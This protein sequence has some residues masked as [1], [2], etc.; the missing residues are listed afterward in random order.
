MLLLA[1]HDDVDLSSARLQGPQFPSR[2]KQ[3][4]LRDVAEIEAYAAPIRPDH[5]NGVPLA[6]RKHTIIAAVAAILAS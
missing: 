1:A 3:E 5:G 2:A 4:Q 6:E